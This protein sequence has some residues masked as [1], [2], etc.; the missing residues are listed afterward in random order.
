[1]MMEN[2]LVLI[3]EDE[4]EIV[5]ILETYFGREG[6]RTVSANDGPTGLAHHLRLRPTSSFSM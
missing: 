2:A 1:M 4:P 6:F 5:D 3:V